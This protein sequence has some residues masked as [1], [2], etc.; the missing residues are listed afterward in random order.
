MPIDY[1]KYPANWKDVIRPD[2]L[3]REQF[4]CK[5]CGIEHKARGYRDVARNF[6]K[7]DENLE[8]WAKRS[9]KRV[10]TIILTIA[11][12]DQDI[13]NNDYSNLAALCQKCHLHHDRPFN[14]V[15]RRRRKEIQGFTPKNKDQEY[16]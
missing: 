11:H 3:R 2:I 6:V 14:E 10:F 12:L 4:H 15:K 16:T 8:I 5:H 7:C 1:K 13:K 9:G